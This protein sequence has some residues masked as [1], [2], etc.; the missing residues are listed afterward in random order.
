MEVIANVRKHNGT[1]ESY[2]RSKLVAA[3]NKTTHDLVGI[4]VGLLVDR[5]EAAIYDGVSTDE[6]RR[7]IIIE[8][9]S[10]LTP[11]Q[12]DWTYIAARTLLQGIHREVTG[13]I[14]SYPTLTE[15]FERAVTESNVDPKVIELFGEHFTQLD[16]HIKPEN[17]D[18]LEYL[19]MQTVYDRY[20]LRNSK[21]KVIELPQHWLMR[22]AIGQSMYDMEFRE[23]RGMT[24]DE[25][26]A[27]IKDLYTVYSS[28]KG[29]SSTPTLFHSS[30]LR[31][32]LS[33]CF[34]VAPQDDADDIMNCMS[35]IAQYSK[36]AGGLGVSFSNI[37]STGSYIRS[38]GGKA[39]GPI[40][41]KRLMQEVL[42]GFDQSG[43]RKGSGSTWL[44]AHHPQFMEHLQLWNKSGDENER[45]M[46]IF[47]ANWVP[48]LLI[49]RYLEARENAEAI[50]RGEYE[51]PKWS[52][53]CPT[54][55]PELMRIHGEEYKERYEQLEAEGKYTSQT[56]AFDL[57]CLMLNRWFQHGVFWTGFKDTINRRYPLRNHFSIEMSNLC[58]EIIGRADKEVSTV[59]NLSSPNFSEFDFEITYED[60]KLRLAWNDDLENTVTTMV[61]ALDR[62]IDSGW[63]PH[64]KG[65]K[66]NELERM[67]GLGE[68]G[69]T[70]C[71][72]KHGIRYDTVDGLLF[73]N[74]V[75]RQVAITALWT[76]IWR[77]KKYGAFPLFEKSTW[78][79]G[80]LPMD[81]ALAAAKRHYFGLGA[82][83]DY[84]SPLGTENDLRRALM[85]HGIRNSALLAVAP[86][87]TIANILG[88]TACRELPFEDVTLKQNLSG[89][90]EV[91]APTLKYDPNYPLAYDVDPIWFVEYAGIGQLYGDQS[92]STNI[93]VHSMYANGAK[94]Q[95]IFETA[96]KRD[97]KTLYYLYSQSPKSDE[98]FSGRAIK[99]EAADMSKGYLPFDG[100]GSADERAT[101]GAWDCEGCQ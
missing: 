93:Y 79:Q 28:K 23:S 45:A 84:D 60:G 47:P 97:V 11:T 81:T 62:V 42:K 51:D 99:D 101:P 58:T 37:R 76:S 31:P 86:T 54:V 36:F 3:I 73:A 29:L 44:V 52:F 77:A 55:A 15:Y 50:D 57:V 94:L 71:M 91:F 8:S 82:R 80:E 13:E 1:T 75:R 66:F 87:A 72:A 78:A 96:Y 30:T 5:I 35:E 83:L 63:V 41:Y 20:L 61:A 27:D 59:C 32:Q 68:M 67:I 38:T 6:I 56:S 70:E 95:E 90:F 10:L 46:Y 40:R 34:E 39:G 92:I 24:V 7:L 33:S 88:T 9:N 65:R 14:L 22:I 4:D 21:G 49:E 19:G 48:S 16:S 64:E 43:K 85:K 25:I 100:L 98:V 26:L 12:P 69:L 17:D 74:E 18:N 89:D 53:F 2:D